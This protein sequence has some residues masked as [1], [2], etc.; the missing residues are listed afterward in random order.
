MFTVTRCSLA[1]SAVL[2]VTSLSAAGELPEV[3]INPDRTTALLPRDELLGQDPGR[4]ETRRPYERGKVPVV[5][6]HGLWGSPRNWDRMIEDLEADPALRTR[7]QFWTVRYASGDSIPYSAHLLRQS[8]RRARRVFDPDGT[9]AA[10][11]RM[12]VVG[13][14]LGGI[15]AKMMVQSG[16]PRLWQ[17]VSRV[18]STR[19]WDRPRNA[20][21]C[22]RRSS[23]SLCQRCAGSS[24]SRPPIAAA[25]WPAAVFESLVRGSA[26]DQTGSVKPMKWFC[27][28]TSQTYSLTDF[29][30][31]SR[32]APV[33]LPRGTRSSRDSASWASI[34]R[35]A[36]IRSL[37]TFVTR[38]GPTAPTGSFPIRAR[39]ST[40]SPRS[41]SYTA[42]TF[43]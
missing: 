43:A 11:E 20:S 13:H 5:L 19:S 3:A 7:F 29:A 32:Q 2:I 30:I 39:T 4:L 23:T 33:S 15:L 41:R 12:V 35:F 42:S 21:S 17:T 22:S 28:T 16:G 1:A 25:R 27:R 37:R 38:R 36:P 34:R 14:S 10:F 31:N 8:L 18:Q 26:G 9:D 6:I 40:A 24:S